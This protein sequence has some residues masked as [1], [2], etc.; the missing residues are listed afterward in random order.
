VALL[1]AFRSALGF[2][3]QGRDV[4]GDVKWGSVPSV[5]AS[6][7]PAGVPLVAATGLMGRV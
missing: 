2:T 7:L 5:P 1:V 4:E 3:F 6:S